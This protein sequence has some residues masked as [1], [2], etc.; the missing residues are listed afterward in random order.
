MVKN[1]V[2]LNLNNKNVYK[3]LNNECEY[4]PIHNGYILH[5]NLQMIVS[6]II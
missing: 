1:R 2:A 5:E 3:Y 4:E 6:E